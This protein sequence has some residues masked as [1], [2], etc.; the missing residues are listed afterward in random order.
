M[1]NS[2]KTRGQGSAVTLTFNVPGELADVFDF[3]VAEDVLPKVLTGYG[4]LPGVVRTSSNTGP[5]DTPGSSR[6]VHL[7]D[8]TTAREQVTAYERPQYFGYRTDR[9]TFTLRHLANSA[10]GQWWFNAQ[11]GGTHVKWTYGFDSKR[12]DRPHLDFVYTP[13]VGWLHANLR[14]ECPTPLY[15]EIA[16]MTETT[17]PT[18]RLGLLSGAN[19]GLGFEVASG[20]ARAGHHVLLGSRDSGHRAQAAAE[21]SS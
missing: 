17:L 7:A 18:E 1:K 11:S 6:T 20:L 13:T 4:F 14:K 8:G 21:L 10:T 19:K 2:I 15:A 5:W 3:V 16:T 12:R 9:Y